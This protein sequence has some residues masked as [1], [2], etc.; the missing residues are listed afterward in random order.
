[1]FLIA[2]AEWIVDDM[3]F[4]PGLFATTPLAGIGLVRGWRPGL[5]RFL[6]TIAV[7]T[8][9][10]IWATQ[11]LG[12]A[13]PQWGGRYIL[14]SGLLLTVVSVV[15]LNSRSAQR[16]GRFVAAGGLAVTVA[17]LVWSAVY[18]HQFANTSRYLASRPEPVLVFGDPHISRDAGSISIQN[19]WLAAVGSTAR[20][21]AAEVVEAAGYDEFGYVEVVNG[22][23]TVDFPGWTRTASEEVGL[24][25]GFIL[26]ITSWSPTG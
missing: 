16:V 20:S 18:T 10:L 14:L 21:E 5:S 26:R 11:Y 24:V 22:P 6:S 25:G 15:N 8:L 1:V 7:V 9:P 4:V 2:F 12:G 19:R 23:S 13:G 17:G 3:G